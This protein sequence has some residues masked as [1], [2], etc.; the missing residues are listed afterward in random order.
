MFAEVHKAGNTDYVY[1]KFIEKTA[2]TDGWER[3]SVTFD[4]PEGGT[5][6]ATIGLGPDASGTVWFDDLQLEK[7]ANASTYN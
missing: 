1:S 7:S 3:R 6:R 4:V 5:V 2:V